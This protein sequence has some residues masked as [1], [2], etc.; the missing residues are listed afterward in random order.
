MAGS[1]IIIIKMFKQTVL[2]YGQDSHKAHTYAHT[3]KVTYTL[4]NKQ[5]Y[6]LGH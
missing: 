2:R 5:I 6:L 3:N 4:T 1:I